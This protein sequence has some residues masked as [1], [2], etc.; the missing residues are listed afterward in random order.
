MDLIL[1]VAFA[2]KAC[3]IWSPIFF[4]YYTQ[5][6]WHRT[7]SATFRQERK[8]NPQRHTSISLRS[9]LAFEAEINVRTAAHAL[10]DEI[11]CR[12]KVCIDESDIGLTAALKADTNEQLSQHV[13]LDIGLNSFLC[14]FY[15]TLFC[16]GARCTDTRLASDSRSHSNWEYIINTE[17]I[18]MSSLTL[19]WDA[20]CRSESVTQRS[21]PTCIKRRFCLWKLSSYRLPWMSWWY[22]LWLWVI[23]NR[24]TAESGKRISSVKSE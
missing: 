14:V 5:S 21:A 3:K 20:D 17:H 1:I 12:N 16:A 13:L 6:Q 19:R 22:Q 23:L 2:E 10:F 24:S 18:G 7:H 8:Q 9:A 4:V 11:L 15:S